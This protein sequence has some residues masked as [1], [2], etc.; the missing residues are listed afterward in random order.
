MYDT[1]R[2]GGDEVSDNSET[3]KNIVHSAIMALNEELPEGERIE[4]EGKT[5]LIG[6]HGALSS[7]QI[8][9]LV[10]HVEEGI[11]KHVGT[12]L[13]LTVD[14]GLFDKNGPLQTVDTLIAF[15]SKAVAVDNE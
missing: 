15:L 9:N 4:P 8:V 1:G 13:D 5:R 14:E 11:S 12:E 6:P 3:I 10:I 2:E 7:L